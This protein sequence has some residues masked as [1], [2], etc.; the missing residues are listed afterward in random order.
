MTNGK[1]WHIVLLAGIMAVMFFLCANAESLIQITLPDTTHT[2]SGDNLADNDQLAAEFIRSVMPSKQGTA[3]V[4][5][6]SRGEKLTGTEAALYALLL[7]DIQA[8]AN[9][10]RLSTN[11]R[12]DG[13]TV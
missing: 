7:N 11:M 1:K 4:A 13:E 5:R 9:G 12:Y 3:L 8:V 10:C 6:S 2:F